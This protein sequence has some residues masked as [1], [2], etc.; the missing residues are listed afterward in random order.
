MKEDRILKFEEEINEA[1][2]SIGQF[3]VKFEQVCY[4]IIICI[5]SI[6]ENC[7]LN[8]QDISHILIS[9]LTAEPLRALLESLVNETLQLNL[10]EEN[11]FKDLLKRFQ[12]LIKERNIA[13][14][15]M[16][17]IGWGNDKT[18]D[19]SKAVGFKYHKN[20]KGSA[21]IASDKKPEDF[22]SLSKEAD[23]L[24]GLFHRL[25]VCLAFGKSI[26]NNFSFSED[27][28]VIEKTIN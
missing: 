22:D 28:K 11:I 16:W 9:G 14:H 4:S 20:K 17:F 25:N 26:Q 10:E 24:F 3:V 27:G 7:G 18:E 12:N 19:F 1:Y 8:N 15:S 2:R 21:P 6:L 13:V 23:L 5:K